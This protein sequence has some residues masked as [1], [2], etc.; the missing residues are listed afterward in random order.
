MITL[1]SFNT[2]EGELFDSQQ[3]LSYI[4]MKNLINH[5]LVQVLVDGFVVGIALF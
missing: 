4:L 3:G 5:V 2:F 1:S